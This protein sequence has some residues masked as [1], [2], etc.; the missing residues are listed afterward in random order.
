M[1]NRFRLPVGCKYIL[2]QP[3]VHTLQHR[4]VVCVLIFYGEVLFDAYDAVQPHI[5]GDFYGV[6]TPRSNHLTARADEMSFQVVF[7]FGV[8]S[9]KSQQSLS[10]SA[11]GSRDYILRQSHSWMGF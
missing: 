1:Y 8:A 2:V 7:T 4:V 9:P 11:W 5:L 10:L 3:L 6:C